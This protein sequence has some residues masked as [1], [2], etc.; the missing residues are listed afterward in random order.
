MVVVPVVLICFHKRGELDTERRQKRCGFA[1][2]DLNYEIRG[3]GALLYPFCQN[4]RFVILVY[5][6]LYMDDY[7]IC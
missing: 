7:L 5:V 1:Y 6:T 2:E 4:L 3:Y